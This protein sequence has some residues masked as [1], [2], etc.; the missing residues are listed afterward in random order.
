MANDYKH[1]T[2]GKTIKYTN[3]RSKNTVDHAVGYMTFYEF[4][5]TNKKY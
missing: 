2:S 4:V 5:A 1:S 3:H